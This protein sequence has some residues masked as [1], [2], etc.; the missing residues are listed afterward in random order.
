MLRPDVLRLGGVTTFLKVAGLAETFQRPVVPHLLP[1]VGVHLACARMGVK[2]AEHV[3]WL[4][5][6]WKAG[7]ELVGGM[8]QAHLNVEAVRHWANATHWGD[9]LLFFLRRLLL[10]IGLGA[11]CRPACAPSVPMTVCFPSVM[12]STACATTP[13]STTRSRT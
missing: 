10:D 9:T 6:L 11:L 8:L 4:K 1:E 5:P 12:T 2:A 7:P 13:S 3:S